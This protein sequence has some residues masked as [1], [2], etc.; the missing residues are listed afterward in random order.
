LTKQK[1]TAIIGAETV[2]VRVMWEVFKR[3]GNKFVLVRTCPDSEL[4][5]VL[6]TLF[7]AFAG[8][9][10]KV[11]RG[12]SFVFVCYEK[13]QVVAVKKEEEVQV[14]EAGVLAVAGVA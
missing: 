9:V 7:P 6:F 14:E 10:L 2:V 3:N 8:E 11:E 4:D 13:T 12:Y 5:N 1:Q